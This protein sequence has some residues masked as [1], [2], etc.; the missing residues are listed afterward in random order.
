MMGDK[1][2]YYFTVEESN[3]TGVGMTPDKTY[4]DGAIECTEEQSRNHDKYKIVKNKVV[5]KYT[6]KELASLKLQEEKQMVIANARELLLANEYRW[7]NKIKWERYDDKTR[8]A[9]MQYYDALVA[10]INGESETIP[11][12]E[13]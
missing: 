8:A 1:M 9:I 2:H 13:I 4:P 10:V 5:D 3:I 7:T 12:L 11:T 6:T